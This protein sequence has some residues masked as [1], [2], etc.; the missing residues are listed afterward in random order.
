MATRNPGIVS[1]GVWGAFV[2]SWN[3]RTPAE[4]RAAADECRRKGHDYR[5]TDLGRRVCLRCANWV[6]E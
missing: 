2:S 5:M 3:R 1:S 6:S 4:R